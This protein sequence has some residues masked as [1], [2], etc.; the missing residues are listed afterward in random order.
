M[1]ISTSSRW[2]RNQN[3]TDPLDAV[4]P[5]DPG[6]WT[7]ILQKGWKSHHFINVFTLESMRIFQT[8]PYHFHVIYIVSWI[9]WAS[10]FPGLRPLVACAWCRSPWT[11]R[12]LA[13]RGV[14]RHSSVTWCCF[15]VGPKWKQLHFDTSVVALPED[16][17]T[18]S[19]TGETRTLSP[20][21]TLTPQH[22]TYML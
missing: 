14:G 19:W 16:G 17:S 20:Q 22:Q 9:S 5:L 3:R 7:Q 6:E 2:V 21:P 18:D 15:Q 12:C 13:H 11:R 4:G 10:S 8:F 1:Q